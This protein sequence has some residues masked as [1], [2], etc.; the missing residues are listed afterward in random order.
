MSL[1]AVG[2]FTLGM[3]SFGLNG[4]LPEIARDLDVTVSVA[5]QLTTIFSIVYAVGSP[6]I[7][8]AT[9]RWDR[10]VVLG[11]GMIIFLLGMVLQAV[12]QDYPVVAGGRV[13]AALGAAAYQSNAYAVAGTLAAPERRGRALAMVAAGATISTVVGVPFGVLAGQWWGWRSAMWI[14]A[15]LALVTALVVPLL[16]PVKL[17]ASTL[18]E[19]L[20]VMIRPSVLLI[21]VNAALVLMP[22]F[23][24]LSYLPVVVA[25]AIAGTLLV[26]TLIGRGAGQVVGTQ[27]TGRL[28]DTRGPIPVLITGSVGSVV[29]LGLLILDR[30]TPWAAIATLFAAGLFVGMLFV[31]NQT[32][33]FSAAPDVPVVAVGLL[34]SILYVAAAAG[35]ALGGLALHLGGVGWLLVAGLVVQLASV[36]VVAAQRK[37]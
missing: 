17:P 26:I 29:A 7:A 3:D 32:R 33:M 37:R 34:G 27:L 28:V 5:G 36:V 20:R 18:V 13:L 16:P 6:V 4:L 14:I 25:P 1:L 19:R 30:G 11:G 2:T 24:V 8:A 22:G 9:G 31:P 21:L 35:S 23:I 10:R 12:G 15:G